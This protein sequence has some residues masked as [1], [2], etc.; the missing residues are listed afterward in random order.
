[1]I[2]FDFLSILFHN[3]N[4]LYVIIVFNKNKFINSSMIL[5]RSLLLTS[6]EIYVYTKYINKSNST[7]YLFK[8]VNKYSDKI[9]ISAT[10][11]NFK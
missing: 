5:Y 6:Y 10:S 8:Y 7:K 4:Q 3:L 2:L 1:M 11:I 9:K